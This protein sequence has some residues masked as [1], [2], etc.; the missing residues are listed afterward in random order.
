MNEVISFLLSHW[1]LSVA[2]LG[3]LGY[4]IYLEAKGNWHGGRKLSP[5]E[6]VYLINREKP[7][8]V[9]IRSNQFYEEGHLLHAIQID[10]SAVL[11]HK[12]VIH[13][14]EEPI[15][16]VCENGM[17]SPSL[18]LQLSKAGFKKV[19]YLQGGIARWK[20]ENLPLVK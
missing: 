14:R 12:K 18:T 9:D 1:I 15:L 2:F 20:E 11:G 10:P 19:Y 5:Q 8:V 6:A 13:H 17:K 7:L 16:L 3:L 4:V